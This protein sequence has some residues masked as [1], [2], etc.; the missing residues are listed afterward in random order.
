MES[1]TARPGSSHLVW[2]IAQQAQEMLT[3]RLPAAGPRYPWADLLPAMIDTALERATAL[4]D[5][6]PGDRCHLERAACQAARDWI[7]LHELERACQIITSSV[8]RGLWSRIEPTDC[9]AMLGLCRWAADK[10]P[11]V[12]ATLRDA[13]IEEMRRLG[14]RRPDDDVIIGT[15]LDGGDASEVA[16]SAG[17]ALP[18]P[19]GVVAVTCADPA[20][21]RGGF[22]FTAPPGAAMSALPE[23]PEVFCAPS[24]DSSSLVALFGLTAGQAGPSLRLVRQTA[25]NML[26]ACEF[27]YG[28]PFVA[29]MA[30]AWTAGEAAQAA[31]EA[32]DIAFLLARPDPL[33]RAA[34]SEDLTLE[35][36]VGSSPALRRKLAARVAEV[37][38]RPDLWATLREIYR[39]DLDRGRTARRLGI[40]RSTLDY[41]LSRIQQLTD[42]CP[43]SVHGILLFTTAQAATQ[44]DELP[45]PS[46]R[47]APLSWT[48]E[49]AKRSGASEEGKTT[50]P[51]APEAQRSRARGPTQRAGGGAAPSGLRSEE[52][53]RRATREDG[54]S[55]A[56]GGERGNRAP[57]AQNSR[58]REHSRVPA[59]AA[60]PQAG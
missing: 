43:T 52:R 48:D 58:V 10:L 33:R 12:L 36:L 14:E 40:H 8:Y 18:E 42:V 19:C 57:E 26:H 6:T 5:L 1:L 46:R 35:M 30:V 3:A 41:R 45:A 34:F 47:G 53:T 16:A 15:L 22:S 31:R 49:G 55:S 32:V 54:A 29:G 39:T 13:Y 38:A 25:E 7:P 11:D 60:L 44:A 37:R 51:G 28:H 2:T 27:S 21:G 4:A 24:W 56:R 23:D 59:S 50:G 17:R 20:G 9:D